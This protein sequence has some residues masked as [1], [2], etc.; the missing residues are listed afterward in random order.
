MGY[1]WGDCGVTYRP[2]AYLGHHDDADSGLGKHAAK[3][4]SSAPNSTN[5]K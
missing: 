4:V 2:R 3:N 5:A 1:S